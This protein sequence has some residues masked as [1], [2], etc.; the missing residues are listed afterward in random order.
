MFLAQEDPPVVR[1]RSPDR[2]GGGE[3]RI[4]RSLTLPAPFAIAAWKR[5]LLFLILDFVECWN[6][7]DEGSTQ[8]QLA[9]SSELPDPW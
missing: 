4:L 7:C 2:E 1:K 5:L 3:I 9:A 6:Y 8:A